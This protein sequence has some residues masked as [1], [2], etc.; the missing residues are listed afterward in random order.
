[1]SEKVI[2]VTAIA[3][4]SRGNIVQNPKD[5]ETFRISIY[6]DYFKDNHHIQFKKGITRDELVRQ[7]G[8]LIE[9]IAEGGG[10]NN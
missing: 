10:N 7:L 2:D 6:F 1:M 9:L 3:R 5:A 4:D 8:N